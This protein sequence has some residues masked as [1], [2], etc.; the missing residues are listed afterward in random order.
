MGAGQFFLNA[1]KIVLIDLLLAGDNALVIAMAVRSLAKAQRRLATACGAGAA[2]ALR[3]VLT[4]VAA[5]LL[6][7]PYVQIAGGLLILWI[8]LKVMLDASDPPDAA[9]APRKMAQAI[10]YIV[11]ADLTMSTDNVL[12]VAGASK[13]HWGLILFGLGLSIPFVVFSANLLASL[14]DRYP[15]LIYLGAAIL[16][17]V[18]GEMILTDPFAIRTL[19]PS[20]AARWSVEAALAIGVVVAG[21]LISAARARRAASASSSAS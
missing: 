12:A 10:W 14:M 4:A 21:K 20:N 15:A 2:V 1:F 7:V 9:P 19:H 18:G 11:V 17:Q 5:R 3:V 6:A 16:G 8:A 13:G